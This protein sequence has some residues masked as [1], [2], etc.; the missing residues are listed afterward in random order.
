[1]DQENSVH[2]VLF[3]YKQEHMAP[4][5][6]NLGTIV[7]IQVCEETEYTVYLPI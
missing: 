3:S 4:H 1:M 5:Y 6:E 7:I 2:T